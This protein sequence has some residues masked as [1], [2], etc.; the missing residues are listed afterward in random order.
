MKK[1]FTITLL[2]FL[3]YNIS[4]AQHPNM[5]LTDIYDN[6]WF[7]NSKIESM[8]SNGDIYNKIQNGI[9]ISKRSNNVRTLNNGKII[10]QTQGKGTFKITKELTDDLT[11]LKKTKAGP[12]ETYFYYDTEGQLLFKVNNVNS[13]VSTDIMNKFFLEEFERDADGKIIKKEVYHYKYSLLKYKA[14]ITKM[15]SLEDRNLHE[16]REYSYDANDELKEIKVK[17]WNKEKKEWIT[18]N[19]D[20]TIENGLPVALDIAPENGG[21][22]MFGNHRKFSYTLMK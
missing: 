5:F 9:P 21:K 19:V 22:M 2:S 15:I 3:T 14:D 4:F 7:Q 6:A 12:L 11:K 13:N 10:K 20:V 16:T 8:T 1:L 18:I 17:T